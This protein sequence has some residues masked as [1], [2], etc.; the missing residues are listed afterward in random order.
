MTTAKFADSTNTETEENAS[1]LT[2]ED[3]LQKYSE[4]IQVLDHGFVRLVDVMGNDSSI[5]QAA[6][7]SY[8]KGTKSAR[9]DRGLIRYLIRNSHTSPL[10][11]CEIKLHCKMPIF[12]ARQWVRHRTASLNEYSARYSELPDEYYVPPMHRVNPQGG[13]SAQSSDETTVMENAEDMLG[14][15]DIAQEEAFT[16][17]ADLV[18]HGVARELSRIVTPMGTYTQWYWKIDLHNLFHFLKLR[19]DAHAQWEIRMFANAIAEIVKDW[20]PFAWEAFDDY[21]LNAVVF[22]SIEQELLHAGIASLSTRASVA[23]DTFQNLWE[24]LSK[25]EREEFQ[26]KTATI[27]VRV[28]DFCKS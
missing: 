23:E 19:M 17:Y 11:M 20:V 21:V 14:K 25:G 9:E 27:G 5:V 7:V 15:L 28:E 6:R 1:P 12:V 2:K 8:G 24:G 4:P 16:E 18:K 22:N 13:V 3:L 26:R 10:E